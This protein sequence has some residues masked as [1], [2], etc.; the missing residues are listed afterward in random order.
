M[1]QEKQVG[2]LYEKS[3]FTVETQERVVRKNRTTGIIPI[4]MK[5]LELEDDQHCFACGMENPDGLRIKWKQEGMLMTA[6]FTPTKKYQGWKGIV[7]GGILA[8]LLDE[9][10]TRLAGLLYKSVV[11]AEMTVRY[12]KPA[13][14]GEKLFVR[15]EV[16]DGSR[17]IIEMRSAIFASDESGILIAQ[18]SGKILKVKSPEKSS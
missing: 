6:H 17:K 11:T 4:L 8:T 9:A 3:R 1:A 15:G 5:K 2:E 16:I 12:V 13:P 18:A 7:H 10:M 14:I